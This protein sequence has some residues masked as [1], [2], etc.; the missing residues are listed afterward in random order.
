MAGQQT[1]G[2]LF[3]EGQDVLKLLSCGVG[4][5]LGG[6][7]GNGG[8]KESVEGLTQQLL[9]EC[10]GHRVERES[11]EEEKMMYDKSDNDMYIASTDQQVPGR[12]ES[13]GEPQPPT[14]H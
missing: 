12:G 14:C 11:C 9:A 7:G 6:G 3:S 8:Q 13:Q 4:G 2:G 10:T 5:G 1:G